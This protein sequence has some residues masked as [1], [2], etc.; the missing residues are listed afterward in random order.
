MSYLF[1]IIF[2]VCE[3][4]VV[5]YCYDVIEVSVEMFDLEKLCEYMC[6]VSEY[7]GDNIEMW[8]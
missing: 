5:F 6:V 4:Y 8:V 3:G 2:L 1:D 7:F